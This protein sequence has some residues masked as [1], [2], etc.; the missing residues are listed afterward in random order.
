[1]SVRIIVKL[2][3]TAFTRK[4]SLVVYKHT[5]CVS[6]ETHIETKLVQITYMH[7]QIA[8]TA[9]YTNVSKLARHF[10]C[11]DHSQPGP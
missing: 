6:V 11:S 1:M 9:S 10:F 5:V 2:L 7:V 3:F 4:V 8:Y